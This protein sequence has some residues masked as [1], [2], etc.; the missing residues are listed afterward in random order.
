[1]VTS[2]RNSDYEL[3]YEVSYREVSVARAGRDMTSNDRYRAQARFSRHNGRGGKVNGAHRRRDKRI[4][5]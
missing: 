2:S 1:M 3:D 5:L 4:Y